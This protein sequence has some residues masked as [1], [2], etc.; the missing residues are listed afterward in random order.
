MVTTNGYMVTKP[1]ALTLCVAVY[2]AVLWVTAASC[3][4]L[5]RTVD[6]QDPASLGDQT[7][8]AFRNACRTT[9]KFLFEWLVQ[10]WEL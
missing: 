3:G 8:E 1:I 5:V 4:V 6:R 7:V 10:S 9:R 2:F